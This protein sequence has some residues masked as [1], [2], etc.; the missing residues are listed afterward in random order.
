MSFSTSSAQVDVPRCGFRDVR[1]NRRSEQFFQALARHPDATIQQLA[2]TR[3]EEAAYSRFLHNPS[4]HIDLLI[5]GIVTDTHQRLREQAHDHLLI[6]GDTSEVNLQ[7]QKGY[8]HARGLGVTGNN[9]APGFFI[10]Q[11]IALDPQHGQPLGC[12]ALALWTRK[13]GSHDRRDRESQKWFDVI[14]AV[15]GGS[16][17]LAKQLTFINDRE[18][19]IFALW[20]MVFVKSHHL[21]TRAKQDRRIAISPACPTGK[22]FADLAG[23]P[24]AATFELDIPADRKTRRT[25]RHST[26]ELRWTTVSLLQPKKTRQQAEHIVLSALEVRERAEDVPPGQKPLVWILLTTH[27]INKL[28]DALQLIQWYVYRWRV[29]DVFSALK[30]RG[31]DLESSTLHHGEALMKLGVMTLWSANR[32]TALVKHRNDAITSAREFFLEEELACMDSICPILEGRTDKQR[33]PHPHH[34]VAWAIW[35]LAR[36]G[37][38]HGSGLPG[39]ITLRRGLERFEAVFLGWNAQLKI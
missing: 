15:D 19:D 16:P 1:L 3:A 4:T 29:E 33:N 6:V 32:L 27:S 30:T 26:M 11:G 17:R 20:Q 28:Q 13:G 39:T 18:G 37:R 5:S 12:A 8:H 2:I 24:L 31:A 36:L 22:L 9:T 21:L 34:S 23:Q 25:A 7:A 14:G 38:W 10:H 35:I